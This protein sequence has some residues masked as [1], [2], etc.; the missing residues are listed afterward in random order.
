MRDCPQSFGQIAENLRI[1]REKLRLSDR[2]N[3]NEILRKFRLTKDKRFASLSQIFHLI[4]NNLSS[5]RKL[6]IVYLFCFII[7]EQKRGSTTIILSIIIAFLVFA[8]VGLIFYFNQSSNDENKS[9]SEEIKMF[10]KILDNYSKCVKNNDIDCQCNY[11]IEYDCKILRERGSGP[12]SEYAVDAKLIKMIGEVREL[13]T[14]GNRI[15]GMD[16]DIYTHGANFVFIP[17]SGEYAGQC[18]SIT[19]VKE[20]ENWK[21][22][23][24]DGPAPLSYCE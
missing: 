12:E 2:K 23:D 19:F 14:E 5:I 9:S 3:I 16:P 7:M 20:R 6:F 24:V 22:F 15:S 13:G 1:F 10:Q 8:I 11:L 4:R 21:A 18:L 17:K